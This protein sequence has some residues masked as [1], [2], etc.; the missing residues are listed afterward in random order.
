MG[1][2]TL[3]REYRRSAPEHVSISR[4]DSHGLHL[5]ECCNP[6]LV[7]TSDII[8]E[9]GGGMRDLCA[10]STTHCVPFIART[11]LFSLQMRI[12]MSAAENGI[13]G[14]EIPAGCRRP[15]RWNQ[16]GRIDFTVLSLFST[17]L[18]LVSLFSLSFQRLAQS[19]SRLR[20]EMASSVSLIM[21]ERK[22]KIKNQK[23]KQILNNLRTCQ[24]LQRKTPK[25]IT[26]S[27]R[28]QR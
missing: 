18:H 14:P 21:R 5:I 15:P 7:E 20:L 19:P 10:S 11:G 13:S 4:D 22:I 25:L 3:L 12:C 8:D 1:Q 9:W 17:P 23:E 26:S 2:V 16:P 28:I 24:T 6:N 27:E